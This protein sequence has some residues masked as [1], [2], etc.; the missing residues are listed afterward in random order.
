MTRKRFIKLIMSKG[1]S[2]NRAASIAKSWAKWSGGYDAVYRIFF[3][4]LKKYYDP[5][6]LARWWIRSPFS[7]SSAFFVRDPLRAGAAII[8]TGASFGFCI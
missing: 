5:G 6:L 2:R 1:Y 8:S 7:P 4:D 3:H